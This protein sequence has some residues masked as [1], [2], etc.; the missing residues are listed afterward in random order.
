MLHLRGRDGTRRWWARGGL[1]LLLAAC[2]LTARAGDALD[3]SRYRGSIV[4]VDFWA[5][6]CAPCRQSFP[7]LNEMQARYRDRGLVV[8]GVNVDRERTEADR[9]LHDV[10]ARFEI[11]Y[12]SDASLAQ[13]YQLPGMPGSFVFGPT[14]ELLSTHIGF[15]DGQRAE[16]EAELVDL[17]ARHVASRR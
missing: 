7:W 15:R 4:V 11:V 9:F 17:L 12:D 8:V 6:W 16:R 1:A 14:G 13:R 10:P 3:L 5:S 2:A